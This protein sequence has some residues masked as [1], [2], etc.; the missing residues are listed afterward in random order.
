MHRSDD[1]DAVEPAM[2]LWLTASTGAASMRCTGVLSKAT[3]RSFL[4]AA[5]EALGSHPARLLVDVSEL[6]VQGREGAEALAR[7]A[8]L[9]RRSSTQ[10]VWRGPSAVRDAIA[11]GDGAGA[12]GC[13]CSAS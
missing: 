13:L 4:D 7:L 5:T 3:R 10:V 1:I 9:A 8:A 6:R 2:V 11:G 12:A